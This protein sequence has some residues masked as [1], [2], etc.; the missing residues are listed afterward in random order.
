MRAAVVC[1]VAAGTLLAGAG[2]A[3]A[4]V[5]F[6]S[7]D[8]DDLAAVLA[9][10]T[11]EQGVCYGWRVLV[12]DQTTSQSESVGSNFGAGIPVDGGQGSC[13]ESV[14]FEAYI[15]Y[16]SESSESEDSASYDVV[17]TGSRPTTSDLDALGL[18]FGG[19]TGEDVDVVVG[20]AVTALP[21]LA[22]D[23]GL[24][25]PIVASPAPESETQGQNA[26]LT[27]SPDSD[28]WRDNRGVVFW[29]IGL[30]LGG[31]VFALYAWRTARKA[32][33]LPAYAG[34]PGERVPDTVPEDFPGQYRGQWGDQAPDPTRQP[35]QQATGPQ[36]PLAPR[37]VPPQSGP[38]QSGPSQ[39]GPPQSV[40]PQAGPQRPVPQQPVPPKQAAEPTPEQPQPAPKPDGSTPDKSEEDPGSGGRKDKE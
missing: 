32:K 33:S 37:P 21:L 27:D 12:D 11:K 7:A 18:D 10:A 5:I 31:G 16:T 34:P 35:S 3:S 26:Q 30:L 28:W 36:Q 25:R 1:A 14:V 20:K 8:A 19:L 17:S 4:D 29:G 9:E 39:S 6:D 40:S 13:R 24:G 38:Q 22:A 2:T 15:T 23:A